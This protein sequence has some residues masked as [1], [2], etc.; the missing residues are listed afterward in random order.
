MA[1]A[2]A[3]H[4]GGDVSQ[5]CSGARGAVTSCG[6]RGLCQIFKPE[7][8]RGDTTRRSDR[9]YGAALVQLTD[10]RLACRPQMALRLTQ[11]D[12]RRQL[13]DRVSSSPMTGGSATPTTGRYS[14][15]IPLVLLL[16]ICRLTSTSERRMVGRVG[17]KVTLTVPPGAPNYD[18]EPYLPIGLL[19]GP[20][21]QACVALGA[22]AQGS[23]E[24]SGLQLH[25]ER[26]L[27]GIGG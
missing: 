23:E 11:P 7:R 27:V 4:G 22:A 6:T 19:S 12:P 20:S 15:R 17:V 13:T 18:G 26:D 14:G 21:T 2:F 16:C 5:I 3:H 24:H 25:L 9:T 8:F 1:R 10:D